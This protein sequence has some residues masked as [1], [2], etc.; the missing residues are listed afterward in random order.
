MAHHIAFPAVLS[1][2][3]GLASCSPKPPEPTPSP[4]VVEKGAGPLLR[5]GSVDVFQ[6]DL[7]WQ[8]KVSHA[9]RRDDEAVAQALA[10]LASRAQLVQAA[11]DSHAENDSGVRAE[12]ARLLSNHLKET[13]LF[14]KLKAASA[15]VPQ[16]RLHEL[17]KA[18]ESRFRSGEKRETAVLWLDPGKD[19]QRAK[20]YAEKLAAARDWFFKSSGLEKHPDKGFAEL[21]VDYSEHQASR[22]K[23]GIVGWIERGGGMDAWTKALAEITFS[24]EKPGDVSAVI[25][26]PEG[27]FLVRYMALKP[28][29]LRPFESVTSDLEQ[30][31]QRRLKTQIEAEFMTAIRAK[32]PVKHLSQPAAKAEKR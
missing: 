20:Q 30:A 8:L 31:E 18:E 5:V 2:L 23:G 28:A 24:L 4:P 19:P 13:E 6:T 22:Y 15:P 11:L 9:G 10:E 17:Y 32:Y 12:I 3:L 16:E 14:P 27:I 26:R 29:I 7:E 25:T 21:G 1:V